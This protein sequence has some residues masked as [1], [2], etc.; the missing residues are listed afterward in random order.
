M[1]GGRWQPSLSGLITPV[2]KPLSIDDDDDN[3]LDENNKDDLNTD[4]NHDNS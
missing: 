1:V 4:A 2:Y 3:S